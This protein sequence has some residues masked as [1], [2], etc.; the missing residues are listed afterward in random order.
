MPDKALTRMRG[1]GLRGVGSRARI[2]R[3]CMSL[4]LKPLKPYPSGSGE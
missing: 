2:Y 3:V 1:F 4:G